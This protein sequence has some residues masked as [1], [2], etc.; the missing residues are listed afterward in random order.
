MGGEFGGM[1]INEGFMVVYALFFIIPLVVAILCLTLNGSANR[2][3]NVILGIIW[4]IWFIFELVSHALMIE[5]VPIAMWLMLIT[6][7]V[8]VVY[9]VYFAWKLPE[10]EE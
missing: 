9:I 10:Q 2:R 1:L 8:F 5:G 4:I 6:G 7:L 3:L